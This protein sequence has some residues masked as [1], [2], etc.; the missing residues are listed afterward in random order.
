MI[1]VDCE[2]VS[3]E[4]EVERTGVGSGHSV[5]INIVEGSID[6]ESGASSVGVLGQFEVGD[7]INGI[8]SIRKMIVELIVFS[9]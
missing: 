3:L 4:E 9:G 7:A 2:D 1:D 5:G 6:E 8:S